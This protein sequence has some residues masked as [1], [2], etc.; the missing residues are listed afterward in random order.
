M[1]GNNGKP[2]IF[3]PEGGVAVWMVNKTGAASFKGAVVDTHGS[4][5]NAVRLVPVDIPD[6]M[7]VIYD[8]GVADGEEV[9]VVFSGKAE[10]FFVSSVSLRY[11]ARITTAADTDD[12]AGKAI[13]EPFPT[14]PFA[15]DKH[16]MEIGHVLEARTGAG[17]A[18]TMLHFN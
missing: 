7:G 9:R 17:L 12:E 14:T 10:V 5:A 4:V 18:L 1:I 11:F 2:V 8:D 13:A 3:T 16:F 6:A 15:T